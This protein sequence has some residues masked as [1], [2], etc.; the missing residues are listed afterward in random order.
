M[1]PADNKRIRKLEAALTA[2]L[3]GEKLSDSGAAVTMVMAALLARAADATGKAAA[4][5]M[6]KGSMEW[7]EEELEAY[8]KEEKL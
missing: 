6:L 4:R 7:L 8:I 2:I 1:T 3:K 5:H